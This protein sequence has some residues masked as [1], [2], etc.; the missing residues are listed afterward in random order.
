MAATIGRI[1]RLLIFGNFGEFQWHFASAV[2]FFSFNLT[3]CYSVI[4]RYF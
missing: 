1:A 4:D 3:G 2:L